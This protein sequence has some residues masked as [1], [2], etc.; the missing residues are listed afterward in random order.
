[1]GRVGCPLRKGIANEN[2][3]VGYYHGLGS[4]RYDGPQIGVRFEGLRISQS[5]SS[6]NPAVM[7]SDSQPSEIK[8]STG[9]RSITRG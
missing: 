5:R 8:S 2:C 7:I 3:Q 1:V 9:V 6:E 4:D